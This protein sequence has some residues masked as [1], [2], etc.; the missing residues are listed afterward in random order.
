M[1]E[2]T[3]IVINIFGGNIQIAPVATSV[4]QNFY[5]NR[6]DEVAD[7]SEDFEGVE[8]TKSAANAEDMKGMTA[9]EFHLYFYMPDIEVL[10]IYVTFVGEWTTAHELAAVVKKM[11]ADEK[12]KNV[13][14]STVVKA[15]FIKSLL[16]FAVR[17]TSGGS[18]DNVRAQ[19]NYMLAERKK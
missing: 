19:I 7:Q 18:V 14:K 12:C 10:K 16:P 13:N 4:I 11:I 5:G 8:N 2:K 3:E 17:L 15:A 9:D 1:N 6:I